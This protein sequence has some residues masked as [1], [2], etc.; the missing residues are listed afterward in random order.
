[1]SNP[2]TKGSARF[3][4][5]E[6][7]GLL[8]WLAGFTHRVVDSEINKTICWVPHEEAGALVADSMNFPF[9]LAKG[10]R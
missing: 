5:A 2:P 7:S 9:D 6:T 8:A 4:V 10:N 1:M 3:I